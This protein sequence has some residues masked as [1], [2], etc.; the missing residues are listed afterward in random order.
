M[1]QKE[2]RP[3]D[4]SEVGLAHDSIGLRERILGAATG[5]L[6]REGAEALTTRAVAAAA[7][8]QA[9]TL[10][11]LFGDKSTLLDAVAE[12]GFLT[13]L[14]EKQR[15]VS[16]PDPLENL[17]AGWDLHIDFG[18]SH[19][20]LFSLMSGT[21]RAGAESPAAAAGVAHLKR[22]IR[23]LAVAGRLRVSEDRAAD[24]MRASGRGTVLTLLEMP[25][26]LR[27][28]GLSA[29][30]REAVIAAMVVDQPA[31]RAAGVVGAATTLRALLPDTPALTDGERVLLYEWLNRIAQAPGSHQRTP[32]NS[33]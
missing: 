21:L 7:G 26:D 13:Y 24:L 4:R 22:Q 17:R 30:A 6:A 11:R 32:G 27:D 9:P 8:I 23:T 10:Y 1:R 19:P 20:A 18:L 31:V 25:E 5:L 2:Q 12:H 3:A 16:S 28:L 15:R 29:L 14:G 33:S